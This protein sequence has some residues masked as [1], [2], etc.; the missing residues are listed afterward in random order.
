MKENEIKSIVVKVDGNEIK[1]DHAHELVIGNLTI[2]PE[3]M[4]EIKSMSTCLFSKDMDDMIDTLINLSCEGNYEDG[5]IMDKMRAVSCV[6]DFLRVI[7]KDK[8]ID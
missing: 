6:R 2:T 8:T 3:M 5:Y 4:R 7:E 1:V